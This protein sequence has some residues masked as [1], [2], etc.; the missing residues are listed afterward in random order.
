MAYCEDQDC[1]EDLPSVMLVRR[2]VRV[3]GK[4][5]GGRAAVDCAPTAHATPSRLSMARKT[6]EAS[7]RLFNA[8]RYAVPPEPSTATIS[9][10]ML[11]TQGRNCAPLGTE[12][13]RQG[14]GYWKYRIISTIMS[15]VPK[16]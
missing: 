7:Y 9:S 12:E 2:F 13:I 8:S 15:S 16:A 6:W 5:E 11:Y 4:G 14:A 1:A 10:M 3:L